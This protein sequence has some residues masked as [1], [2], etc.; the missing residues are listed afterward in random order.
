VGDASVQEKTSSRQGRHCCLEVKISGTHEV[1]STT[2]ALP[3][4]GKIN[5]LKERNWFSAHKKNL[6]HPAK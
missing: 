5:T 6:S 1:L 3:E 2:W 4:G